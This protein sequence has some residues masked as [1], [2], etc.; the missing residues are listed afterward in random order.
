MLASELINK[1]IMERIKAKSP[2]F[3]SLTE[4]IEKCYKELDS[5]FKDVEDLKQEINRHIKAMKL[6]EKKDKL[7]F[8]DKKI[9]KSYY[10]AM[11]EVLK[12]LSE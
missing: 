2:G 7:D 1:R 4:E 3:F 9:F 12:L 6:R 8:N 11:E 10:L 5:R